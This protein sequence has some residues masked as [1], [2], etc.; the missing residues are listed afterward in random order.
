[1][2]AF[3]LVKLIFIF[4]KENVGRNILTIGR[5]CRKSILHFILFFLTIACSTSYGGS[6]PIGSVCSSQDHDIDL[7]EWA[8]RASCESCRTNDSQVSSLQALTREQEFIHRLKE[9]IRTKLKEKEEFYKRLSQC[10]PSSGDLVFC[11]REQTQLRQ[12]VR[13]LWL[14]LRISMALMSPVDPT[15]NAR[16]QPLGWFHPHPTHLFRQATRQDPLTPDEVNS[17]QSLFLDQVSA[18][19]PSFQRQTSKTAPLLSRSTQENPA[20]DQARVRI[21]NQA[22]TD[23]MSLIGQHPA[24]LFFSSVDLQRDNSPTHEQIRTASKR[25]A[26]EIRDEW[27]RLDL[28]ANTWH[29]DSESSRGLMA[30]TNLIQEILQANP[31]LCSAAARILDQ[32]KLE[33]TLKDRKSAEHHFVASFLALGF[34]STGVGCALSAAGLTAADYGLARRR[35][36]KAFHQSVVR[37]TLS[38]SPDGMKSAQYAQD[39]EDIILRLGMTSSAL[40]GITSPRASSSRELGD[41]LTTWK[42]GSVAETKSYFRMHVREVNRNARSLYIR[43]S[44]LFSHTA[45]SHLKALKTHDLE[46]FLSFPELSQRFQYK[47]IPRDIVDGLSDASQYARHLSKDGQ[48]YQLSISES[49]HLMWGYSPKMLEQKILTASSASERTHW[50]SLL[51]L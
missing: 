28:S 48:Y 29:P 41:R 16:N 9:N 33:A 19:V 8:A 39:R 4:C 2:R 17:T 30:Y 22:R 37:S 1:M 12:K 31:R 3:I 11:N 20:V 35:T 50:A 14:R 34:C 7:G 49:L 18:L 36:D 40:I 25:I 21:R 46:K 23:Y 15:P 43:N 45:T 32:Q 51:R 10:E 26:D 42:P 24:L 5:A 6:S 27:Q 38:P 13:T 47:G 44:E